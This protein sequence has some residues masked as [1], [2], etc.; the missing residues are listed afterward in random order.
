MELLQLRYFLDSA[1]FGSIVRAAEKHNVPASSVSAAVR[2]L[3]KE[4]GHPL[5]DRSSNRI[6]LNNNGKRLMDSLESVFSELDQTV[7]DIANPPDEQ[8]IRLLVLSH[9]VRVTE[10]MV[11]YQTKHPAVTFDTS[12]NYGEDAFRDYDII[13]GPEDPRFGEYCFYEL[14]HCR[15]YLRASESHPLYGRELTLRQL[16]DQPF[17]TMGG[18][19]HQIIVEAC[20]RAGFTPKVTARVND[21]TCYLK[22]LRSGTV[23]GHY[24]APEHGTPTVPCLNVTD[25]TEYQSIRAYYREPVTGSIKSFLEF[26]KTKVL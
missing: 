25:F 17:V 19:M 10:C 12:I 22:L 9:R 13:I 21:I 24:R 6:L 3:E 8:V 20:Q 4:L 16:K 26:L 23:I 15:V 5:F 18:N 11:E 2:R 1:H 7:S 14:S